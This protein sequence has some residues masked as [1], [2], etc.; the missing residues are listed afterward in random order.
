MTRFIL[1]AVDLGGSAVFAAF[2]ARALFIHAYKDAAQRRRRRCELDHS[3]LTASI[4]SINVASSASAFEL[5][6]RFD[7]GQRCRKSF[8]AGFSS[9]IPCPYLCH[10]GTIRPL[11]S[12]CKTASTLCRSR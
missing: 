3:A 8:G 6:T 11:S 10:N 12:N 5:L 4:G 1:K 9:S 2:C 7:T